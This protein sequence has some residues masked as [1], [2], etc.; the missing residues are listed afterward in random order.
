MAVSVLK[1]AVQREAGYLATTPVLLPL[2]LGEI[3]AEVIA[4]I[5][6]HPAHGL[7][8][9]KNQKVQTEACLAPLDVPKTSTCA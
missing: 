8:T 1:L 2:G 3:L 4:R 5:D 7:G 9:S 6:M